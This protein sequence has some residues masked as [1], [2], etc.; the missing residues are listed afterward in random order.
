MGSSELDKKKWSTKEIISTVVFVS[1]LL[2]QTLYLKFSLELAIHEEINNRI[3][4]IRVI[5]EKIKN[6]ERSTPGP[7]EGKHSYLYYKQTPA[8]KP[9][10]ELSIFTRLKKRKA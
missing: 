4:D 1:T 5:E 2:V 6:L 10:Y 9:E 7:F 8:E 3:A